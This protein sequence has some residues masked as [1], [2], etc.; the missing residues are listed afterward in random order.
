MLSVVA[1]VAT[2]LLIVAAAGNDATTIRLPSDGG[3]GH[4]PSGGKGERRPT[5][6]PGHAATAKF[7]VDLHVGAWTWSRDAL[8]PAGLVRRCCIESMN[9]RTGT[10]ATLRLPARY[11]TTAVHLAEPSQEGGK[12][13]K[14][15]RGNAAIVARKIGDRLCCPWHWQ[16]EEHWGATRRLRLE[17]QQG[18]SKAAAMGG[19]V[20]AASEGSKMGGGGWPGGSSR[21]KEDEKK[22]EGHVGL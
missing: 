3:K 9:A 1:L 21:R 19:A 22:E 7:A 12:T 20:G 14:E 2:A 8:T 6:D 5:R 15:S 11:P 18:C 10:T 4:T 17:E 13:R 16:Q